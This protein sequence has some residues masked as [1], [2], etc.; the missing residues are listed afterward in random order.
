MKSNIDTYNDNSHRTLNNNTPNQI[1]RDND[2]HMA[3]HINNSLHN[4]QVHKTVPFDTGDKVRILR[5][6]KKLI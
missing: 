4:Q 3:R 2:V 5:K 1:F 6:K